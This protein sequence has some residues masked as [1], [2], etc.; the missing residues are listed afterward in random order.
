MRSNLQPSNSNTMSLFKTIGKNIK[1]FR[2]HKD[3][4]QDELASF[5]GI[6]RELIN[7]YENGSREIP[8]TNLEKISNWFGIDVADLMEENQDNVSLKVAF[9][10]RADDLNP[11]DYDAI[12]R[13]QRIISNFQKMKK[14]L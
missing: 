1:L 9:A 12:S 6:S 14:L 2:Q 4:T 7:Y 13:F 8:I 11:A 5:T 3:M 10:F